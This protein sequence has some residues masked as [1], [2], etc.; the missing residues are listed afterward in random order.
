MVE[1]RLHSLRTRGAAAYKGIYALSAGQ[2]AHDWMKGHA[3]DKVKYV[4]V[5]VDIHHVFPQ[6]WCLDNKINDE[7][8]ESIVNK[9]PLSAET[10]RTI[11]GSAPADYLKV[12]EKKAR[13]D[14]DRVDGLLRTH[15]VDP[16]AMR[17]SDFDAHFTRRREALVQLV[18]KAIGK[19]VQRDVSAGE[20]EE[21][22]EH[23]DE[24]NVAVAEDLDDWEAAAAPGEGIDN[25]QGT[26]A[27]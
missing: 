14:E 7:R 15:L 11:G 2:R 20:P 27:T 9:T 18:G 3:L 13:V 23:F 26:L 25:E 22:L 17:A 8:R 16:Q 1:S 12:I 24:D 10:N 6:K 19:A 4:N 21:T 5:A